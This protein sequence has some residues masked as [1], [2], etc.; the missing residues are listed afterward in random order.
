MGRDGMK[1]KI[2]EKMLEWKKL[3]NGHTALLIEGARRVGKSYIVEEFAK[4]EYQSY[5]LLD[6]KEE[7]EELNPI[8]EILDHS[9]KNLDDFFMALMIITG[10]KLIERNTLIVFDEVQE[11]PRAREAIKFLVKDGRYD[12]IETGSLISI[13]ENTENIQIPSEEISVEMYPMDFEEFLWALGKEELWAYIKQCFEKRK[14][15]PE[16][17]HR[18]AMVL[19][20]KYVIVGGM[21]MAVDEYSKTGDFIRADRRKREVLKLYMDD[22]RKHDNKSGSNV[23]MIF[24]EIPSQ[25]AKHEK[26][27]TVSNIKKGMRFDRMKSDLFWLSDAKLVNIAWKANE[28]NI[29]FRLTREGNSFKCYLADTGLLIS[30][31]FDE[32]T[33]ISSQLY[34]SLMF[35]TLT[36]NSGMIVENVIAQ[37]LVATGRK[38][39]YFS[40]FSPENAEDR[41]EIDFL[42]SNSVT[43]RH[44]VHPIEVKSGKGY[45]YS[46]L[47]KFVERYKDYSAEPFIL[48]EGQLT[49]KEGITLLPLYMTP[50]L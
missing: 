41:M 18:E 34:K 39:Y 14:P 8:K 21:P 37:M 33:E 19:F 11:Y 23:M 46:S 9:L 43:S 47:K 16:A 10:K 5:V 31:V 25:L 3:D 17:F 13:R 27:F 6:F 20:R 15:L 1:R 29:G 48:H 50:L 42:I 12:Y 32:S 24:D 35:G 22:I 38:N 2:Y 44:N 7:G 49:V 4:N 36:F 40:K 45:S 26:K 30:F 28:P